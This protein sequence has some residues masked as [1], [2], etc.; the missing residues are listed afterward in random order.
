MVQPNCTQL[1]V[2]FLSSTVQFIAAIMAIRLIRPTGASMA[3]LFLAAGF[4][5]QGARRLFS[6]FETLSGRLTCDTLSESL[7]L[8]ISLLMLC[9]ILMFKPLFNKISHSHLVLKEKQAELE[10]AQRGLM[11]ANLSLTKLA[12]LDGLTGVPNRR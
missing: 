2:I 9:G 10:M 11:E 1:L 5:V 8:A 12:M 6:L 3:W 7:G 4:S